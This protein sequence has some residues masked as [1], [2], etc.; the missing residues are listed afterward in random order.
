M[1]EAYQTKVADLERAVCVEQH[2]RGLQIPVDGVC[3]VN[4]LD[5]HQHLHPDVFEQSGACILFEI[6]AAYLI[7]EVLQVLVR[8][9]LPRVNDAV[10]IRL[11]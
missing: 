7:Q 2:I 3:A 9:L 11:H 5:R 8:Q 6:S 1:P 4:V 10:Q